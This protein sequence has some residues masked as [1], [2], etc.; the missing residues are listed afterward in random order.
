MQCVSRAVPR[1]I[2]VTYFK[3]TVFVRNH[4]TIKAQLAMT[5][6]FFRAHDADASHDL[7]ARLVRVKQK[8][9]KPLARV[10]AGLGDEHKMLCAFRAGDKPFAAIDDPV[11]ALL[12]RARVGQRRI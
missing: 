1:R 10:V 8:R 3:Q 2:C 4:Q 9:R 6:V 11:I 7:P 5:A 12:F